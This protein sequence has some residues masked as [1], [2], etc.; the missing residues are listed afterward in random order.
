MKSHPGIEGKEIFRLLN[1][2]K[3][4]WSHYL[5][6]YS[7]CQRHI[8]FTNEEKTNYVADLLIYFSDT[9]HLL[10]NHKYSDENLESLYNSV[11]ALQFMFVQQDL[12]DELLTIFKLPKS[13]VDSKNPIRSIRNELIGHPIRRERNKNVLISSVFVTS[14]T[15]GD[16]LEYIQ[17]HI[18]NGYKSRLLNYK[19][20]ELFKTH[21]DYLI[22]N[23]NLIIKKIDKILVDFKREISKLRDSINKLEFTQLVENVEST[24]NKFYENN[25]L[26]KIDNIIY[27]YNKSDLHNRYS[28]V[29]TLYKQD[30]YDNIT[31]KI[32]YINFLISG[33][34]I[35]RKDNWSNINVLPN[36]NLQKGNS[37]EHAYEKLFLKHP[38][39]DIEFFMNKF[40]SNQEVVT[41]LENMREHINEE[42]EYYS[43][44]EYLGVLFKKIGVL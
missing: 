33:K 44:Y 2:I 14:G 41:E 38:I 10:S 11:A 5:W 36:E 25:Y 28:N 23:F 18:D 16:T 43:S 29:V 42:P 21:E 20:L 31:Y 32:D 6:Q 12:M 30:L 3:D 37:I 26:Y 13:S 22:V 9:I 24:Y 7:I 35:S 4:V 19:W 40:S 15:H 8:R 34:L 27:C 39:F 1:K 17:Y